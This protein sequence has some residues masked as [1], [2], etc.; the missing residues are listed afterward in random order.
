MSA[1]SGRA[2]SLHA[3]APPLKNPAFAVSEMCECV[4]VCVSVSVCLCVC[5]CVGLQIPTKTLRAR[6]LTHMHGV[7]TNT[8]LSCR[9]KADLLA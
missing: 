9:A 1:A 5:V 4:R 3:H 8:Y 6:Y 7:C 2:G